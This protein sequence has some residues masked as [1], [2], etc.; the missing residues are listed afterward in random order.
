[1]H[2]NMNLYNYVHAL[3]LIMVNSLLSCI[4][5]FISAHLNNNLIVVAKT[6]FQLDTLALVRVT[7]SQCM[8]FWTDT[9]MKFSLSCSNIFVALNCS[10]REPK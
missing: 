1:M 8:C 5:F 9:V 6:V 10:L 2:I 7:V 4:S 3:I